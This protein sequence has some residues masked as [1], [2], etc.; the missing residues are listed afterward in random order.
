VNLDTKRKKRLKSWFSLTSFPKIIPASV[1]PIEEIS[2]K[3]ILLNSGKTVIEVDDFYIIIGIS[4]AKFK[5]I[6]Q[7]YWEG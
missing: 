3:R 1:I 5:K 7:E 6:I 2:D 4:P